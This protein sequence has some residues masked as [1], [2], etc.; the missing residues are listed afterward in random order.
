MGI[1]D[2]EYYLQQVKLF[3]AGQSLDGR[4]GREKATIK[5]KSTNLFGGMVISISASSIILMLSFHGRSD[6]KRF[7]FCTKVVDTGRLRDAVV[8]FGL[9]LVP[10]YAG[11]CTQ[12]SQNLR[13]FSAKGKPE[14]VIV[15][16]IC[17][18]K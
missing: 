15:V 4:D 5:R 6:Q 9:V 12:E 8:N 7:V 1:K 13:H 18:A 2:F 10:Q 17:S 3:L 16:V 11:G 14:A